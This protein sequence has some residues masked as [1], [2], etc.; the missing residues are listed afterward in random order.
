MSFALTRRK[1]HLAC[2]FEV[3]FVSNILYVSILSVSL[4][5][6]SQFQFLCKVVDRVAH[7]LN[8]CGFVEPCFNLFRIMLHL[9]LEV[10]IHG[11]IL[12]RRVGSC[13][14]KT[15]AYDREAIEHFC[16][17]VQRKHSHKNHIHE[18]NHLLARAYRSF[19]YSHF[20][21]F[22]LLTF[23]K[24]RVLNLHEGLS[25]KLFRLPIQTIQCFRQALLLEQLHAY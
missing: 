18:V 13:P 25:S 17:N 6:N 21:N 10:T 22:L 19:L 12:F 24:L 16:G 14:V 23:R 8:L 7:A 11:K 3:F 2:S 4:T 1:H 5:N 9:F 15:L 20:L